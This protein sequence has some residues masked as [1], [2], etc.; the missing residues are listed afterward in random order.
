MVFKKI[1]GNALKT[2][3]KTAV[4]FLIVFFIS[5]CSDNPEAGTDIASFAVNGYEQTSGF[6][7]AGNTIMSGIE[8]DESFEAKIKKMFENTGQ[9]AVTVKEQANPELLAAVNAAD[10]IRIQEL[11]D[12]GANI[13]AAVFESYLDGWT[14]YILEY[15][16]IIAAV[17]SNDAETVKMLLQAGASANAAKYVYCDGYQ[18]TIAS[19][20]SLAVKAGN[21]EI[22]KMLLEAG[23]DVN[24]EM[25]YD[26]LAFDR[27]KRTSAALIEAAKNG[28][29][30]I[31]KMF[32]KY[33]ADANK[34]AVDLDNPAENTIYSVYYGITPLFAAARAGND[35]ILNTL[36]KA[37]ADINHK[38]EHYDNNILYDAVNS[39]NEKSVEILLAKG[40]NAKYRRWQA[41]E[42]KKITEMLKKAGA[43]IREKEKY[44]DN[45]LL[46]GLAANFLENGPVPVSYERVNELIKSGINVNIKDGA[47]RT[48]LM[49]ASLAYNPEIVQILIAAGANINDTDDFGE[50]VFMYASKAHGKRD[51][52]EMVKILLSGEKEDINAADK[53]GATALMFSVQGYY[54][55]IAA[56][57]YLIRQGAD[58]DARDK[59]GK[60]ALDYFFESNARYKI[61]ADRGFTESE[62]EEIEWLLKLS[63]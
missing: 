45:E 59:D 14:E 32:L 57:K 4:F 41:P 56:V 40:V 52:E 2:I 18:Y 27:E 1:N 54:I 3:M 25:S 58:V 9:E 16:I 39:G 50:T 26:F 10:K 46:N 55:D 28:N 63:E 53:D 31:T 15:D 11:I 24:K 21:E 20:L 6:G 13:N 49:F 7:E 36:I 34:E 35:K 23:A 30:Q 38:T 22:I 17:E 8:N 12:T 47:G 48:P 51:T 5:G 44:E 19:A 42:N 60:T 37:G 29:E 61:A 33:G 43:E 62:K